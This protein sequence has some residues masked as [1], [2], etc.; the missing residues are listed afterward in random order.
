M[1]RLHD[2]AL[3]AKNYLVV[4]E[5][6]FGIDWFDAL[7]VAREQGNWIRLLALA[8][9][10]HYGGA[11]GEVRV[12]PIR[13]ERSF[14]ME[15][16]MQGRQCSSPLLWGY[17]CPLHAVDGLAADHLFP[18][19]LGGPTVAE[20]KIYLCSRHNAVK[21]ADIHI[22]PWERGEPPWLQAVIQRIS[23]AK[24]SQRNT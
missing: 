22:Y 14:R 24:S 5:W 21:G 9:P 20:N 3:A 13:G 7:K 6:S 2:R 23:A 19:S 1:S 11:V 4:L 17:D 15:A 8:H 16:G 12:C 10:E 18:Y